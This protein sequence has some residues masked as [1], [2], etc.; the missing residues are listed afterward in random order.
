[1]SERSKFLESITRENAAVVLVDHQVG[2]LSGVRDIPV[3]ELK[4]NVVALARAATVLGIPLVVT[5]T[6]ADSMWGPTA[7]ELV[8][9]LPAGQK[10]IDRS[11]VNAWH[12][13]RVR[14]TIEA[15]GR[16]KLIF[17]GV[18]LEVCAALPAI[19]ATAAG[20]DAYVA[21]DASG[22]FSQAKREAGLLRM[23]QAGV[24]ASDYATLM[25]EA[26]AD[27]AAPESGALYAALD[28]PFAVLVGQISAA[29]QA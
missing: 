9:A 22:T 12:D 7:P 25:V 6:A 18:S 24:I 21:V 13:D 11:T 20:Y 15:T 14:E 26:L 4:H 1:M 10:I 17:A 8:E 27:N 5:T 23:Q 28:M 3:G 29:C 16:Q 2:L 19:S